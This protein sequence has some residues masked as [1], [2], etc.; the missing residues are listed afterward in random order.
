MERAICFVTFLAL[1]VTASDVR[2]QMAG[3]PREGLAVAQQVCSECHAIRVEQGPSPNSA[4][5][6][7]VELATTPGMTGI[8]LFVA[9]TKP[10]AGMPMFKLSSAQRDSVVA[11]ILS[12][13]PDD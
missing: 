13:K 11:Y 12:L 6:T 8:P 3:N 7:F 9:L 10:H 5:P 1:S 4:S 2:A